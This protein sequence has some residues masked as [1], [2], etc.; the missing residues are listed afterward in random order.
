MLTS[1]SSLPAVPNRNSPQTFESDSDAFFGSLPTM[2]SELNNF[3]EEVNELGYKSP[4]TAATTENI[5]LFGLPTIDGRALLANN[6]VLVKNQTNTSQNGIYTAGPSNW[7]RS[8]D[9]DSSVKVSGA[10]VPVVYGNSQGGRVYYTTFNASLDTLGSS[11]IL[12]KDL[13]S[14]AIVGTVPADSGGTG[15]SS[16][17]SGD[18][19][20]AN[21]STSLA[22]LPAVSTGNVLKSGS[23][24]SW[25][26]VSLTSEISG[27]LPAV[28][29]GTGI[30]TPSIAGLFLTSTGSGWSASNLPSASELVPGGVVLSS[31][32]NLTSGSPG[33]SVITPFNLRNNFVVKNYSN[34]TGSLGVDLATN[35]PSWC[36]FINVLIYGVSLSGTSVGPSIVLKIGTDISTYNN[37]AYKSSCSGGGA[38]DTSTLSL[39]VTPNSSG[40]SAYS[41]A[42]KFYRVEGGKWVGDVSVIRDDASTPLQFSGS[43]SADISGYS[44]Q[45]LERLRITTKN[46]TNQTL[47]G[48]TA[49]DSGQVTVLYC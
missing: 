42:I 34:L 49:F 26:K 33:S 48:T 11:P 8:S 27:I 39:I 46:N 19:L 6:R 30:S 4:V 35:I 14:S 10:F 3:S 20:Y 44:V 17:T 29:G 1:I 47:D 43:F 31:P 28:N 40:T 25:G 15:I 38:T 22:K 7:V 13:A 24:P 18:L 37:T 2:L 45:H 36:S 12:F 5:S 41:G 32:G 23:A 21:S 16:Y 9:M